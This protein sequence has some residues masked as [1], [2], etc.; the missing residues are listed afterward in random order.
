MVLITL[1]FLAVSDLNPNRKNRVSEA[2]KKH[3]EAMRKKLKED[4]DNR[5]AAAKRES[6]ALETT[7]T[8]L[9]ACFAL[10]YSQHPSMDIYKNDDAFAGAKEGGT[11]NYENPFIIRFC[12]RLDTASKLNPRKTAMASWPSCCLVA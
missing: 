3:D 10:D 4:S 7:K 8:H 2:K 1:T 6:E 9:K 5:A 11:V 12:E